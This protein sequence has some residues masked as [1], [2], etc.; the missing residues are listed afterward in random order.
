MLLVEIARRSVFL[1]RQKPTH[2]PLA[3]ALASAL[4]RM[5]EKRSFDRSSDDA[6]QL[7]RKVSTSHCSPSSCAIATPTSPWSPKRSRTRI[8]NMCPSGCFAI[9]AI[10]GSV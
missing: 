4:G 1:C 8:E 5:R 9:S 6:R 2:Q 7:S 10:Y 3:A